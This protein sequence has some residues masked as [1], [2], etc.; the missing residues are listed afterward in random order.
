MNVRR[1]RV[2]VVWLGCVALAV[3]VV[4]RARY[5]TDLSAFL[6][7]HPTPTQQLLVDQLREGPASRLILIALEQGDAASRARVS[8]GLVERLRKDPEFASVDNGEAVA[9]Q[10]D[11]EFLFQHRYLLSEAVNAQRFTTAGLSDAIRETIDDL[12]SPAGLLFKSLLPRDPTGELA[13]ILDQ[14]ARSPA[15]QSRDGVWVSSD[16]TRALAVA[17]TSATGSDTD[18]QSR[19]IDAIRAAFAAAAAESPQAGNKSM[20][21][22]LSGPGVFAVAARAKIERAAVRLSI[23]SSILVV[24]LLLLVYRSLSALGLGLLPVATGALVGIAAVALGFGAVHG[25]TLGFGI[26]L[27]GES[28]DYSIYFFVQSRQAQGAG[29]ARSWQQLWWPTI[30]LGMF[31][32]VCGFASLLPSGFPG[33]KQLGLYS[34]SGLIAAALVTRYVLPALLPAG[35]TIHDVRPVGRKAGALLRR[36]QNLSGRAIL[37]CGAVLVALALAV[38]YHDRESL[39]NRELSAL[40]P[41]SADDQ[42]Y[43]AK[44]RADLGAADVRDLVIVSGPDMESILRGAERAAGVLQSLVDKKLIGGFENPA[45]YV[46]SMATQESRRSSLPS[47]ADLRANLSQ[48]VAGLPLRADRL[49]P[50]L[51]DVEATRHAALVTPRD[52]AG[53]SLS[54]GFD[55]LILHQ[56]DQWNALLPLRSAAAGGEIDLGQVVAALKDGQVTEARV[57]DLKR[58]SDALYDDYLAEAIHFSLAGFLALTALLLIALR[59]PMRVVRVLAPLALAVLTVAAGLA[60][61]GVQLSILHL[62]GMLLIVAVG[63]NYALFFDRQAN[64]AEAGDEVVTLAALVI[65][66]ASTVIGFGL[67]SFSQVPVLVALGTTVA[68]GTFLALLFAATGVRGARSAH[69]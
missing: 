13:N 66:N 27:I 52:L 5:S 41:I 33:L 22:R 65:A 42:N 10:R 20:Q 58:E 45:A 48:A 4:A 6:P 31:T 29:A 53:T 62:V 24:S 56:K 35:F 1:A 15:P 37:L 43:D 3:I 11:R 54:A 44:L 28:V 25:I 23:A 9:G 8:L 51:E 59:S 16:G 69:A 63:S 30:R 17:Q 32:S 61:A 34:I 7:A 14:L 26:T 67:L 38:L 64:S 50:F 60:A 2:L 19:A 68:P 36:A 47:A 40:S 39:W 12:A 46:P 55:A 49:Q 18:A 21:L 57:L